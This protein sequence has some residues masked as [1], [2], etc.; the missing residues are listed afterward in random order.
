MLTLEEGFFLSMCLEGFLYGLYSGIFVLYFQFQSNKSESTGRTATIVFYAVCLLYVLSTVDFVCDLVALVLEVSANFMISSIAIVQIIAMG[1][2]DFLAQCILIYRCWIVWGQDIRVVIIP[3]LLAITYLATWL[4]PDSVVVWYPLTITSLVASMAV[5]TLVTGLIVFRILKVSLEVKAASTSVERTLGSTGG[6]NLRHV[7]FIII[8]S[9][10]A[11]FAIQLA[12]I[13][14]FPLSST[15]VLALVRDFLVVSNEMFNGIIPTIILVRVSLK[16]SFDDKESFKE[17]I[18]SLRFINPPSDPDSIQRMGNL[19]PQDSDSERNE[20]IRFDNIPSHPN[21]LQVERLGVG[22]SS[23]IPPQEGREDIC[24][25]NP[26]S[27]PSSI[28][29]MGS[30]K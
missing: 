14:L 10:M 12:S 18:E 24:F 13:I 17:A 28:Q 19:L 15:L 27:Y 11:L 6:T 1:C 25:N 23:S 7:I 2:C 30:S 9:G 26:P 5:N 20:D 29:R 3:S 4:V 22:S 16:L 21:T 8:E